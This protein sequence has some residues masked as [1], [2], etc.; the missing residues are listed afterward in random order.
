MKAQKFLRLYLLV[1]SSLA[2]IELSSQSIT[3][4][5]ET[6]NN[7]LALQTDKDNRLWIVYFGK[8]LMNKTDY[9]ATSQQYRF[10]DANAGIYNGAYTAAGTWNLSEP[11]LQVTHTDGNPSTELKY[12]SHKATAEG[13]NVTLTNIK[14]TD[15]VYKLNVDLVLQDMEQGKCH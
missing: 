14:L 15:P 5:I 13:E 8:R 4:P 1:L 10:F 9:D 6:K 11:A 2:F 7:A 12:V 3:I